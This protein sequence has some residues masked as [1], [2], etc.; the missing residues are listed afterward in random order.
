MLPMSSISLLTICLLIYQLLKDNHWNIQHN[1][2]LYIYLFYSCQVL[3]SLILWRSSN[4]AFSRNLSIYI[5]LLWNSLAIQLCLQS[6][7]GEL[8]LYKPHGT[9]KKFF[10]FKYI[11]SKLWMMHFSSILNQFQ[12]VLGST[13]LKC[14][15]PL[16][17]HLS[18]KDCLI[19]YCPLITK[20]PKRV[21]Y[22]QWLKCF[23]FY[24]HYNIF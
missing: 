11:P 15:P 19:F 8:R 24:S 14:I 6:L 5:F 1:F 2:N 16:I 13:I 23:C 10:F 17:S 20:H 18:S 21:V 3:P 7:V 4:L 22:T 9:V 12:H